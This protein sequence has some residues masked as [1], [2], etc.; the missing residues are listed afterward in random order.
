[1]ASQDTQVVWTASPAVYQ[2]SRGAVDLLK[3]FRPGKGSECLLIAY[4]VLCTS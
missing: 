4:R 3:L 1:M 2:K